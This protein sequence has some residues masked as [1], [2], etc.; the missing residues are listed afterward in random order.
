MIIHNRTDLPVENKTDQLFVCLSKIFG[1]IDF[2]LDDFTCEPLG[3]EAL[4]L[5][6][7]G[8]YHLFGDVKS[9][10]QNL[11]WSI[12]LKVIKPDSEEKNNPQHHNYWRREALLFESNLLDDLPGLTRAPIRYLVEEQQD[13]TVWLWME[14]VKGYFAHTKEQFEFIAHQL[15]MFNAEYLT[16]RAMPNEA[17]I[18]RRWL[19]SWTT[20]SRMYA[21]SP[22]AYLSRLQD[23]E[24]KSAWEWLQA[25]TADLDDKLSSLE[26]LPRV[27]AHQDLSHKNMLIDMN[28]DCER[29]VLM[30]WQFLSISGIGE[31][32]GKM[33]G[34]NMSLDVIPVDQYEAYQDSLFSFYIKGMRES[35]WQGNEESAR[36][37]YC[38]S[39]ALRSVWE[40][41]QLCSLSVQLDGD[42]LNLGLQQ[43]VQRLKKIIHMQKEMAREAE[44]LKE[45]SYSF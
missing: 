7:E 3:N 26:R 27:L 14:H 16:T 18:C 33:F 1:D 39:A 24:V 43:R 45:K 36:Y 32:L 4:N 20:S 6:T 35:G 40:V 41:P 38:L 13:G 8:I 42:P 44:S 5:T 10:N 25:L 11:P 21:P 34:V 22:E 31:D 12:V 29:L 37:G 19:K 23:E 2:E 30:D 28:S 17:W 9:D 15:G